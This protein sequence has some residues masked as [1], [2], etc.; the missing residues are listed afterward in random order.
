MDVTG[1]NEVGNAARA[2]GA[3]AATT[4]STTV[5][6]SNPSIYA[7][8]ENGLKVPYRQLA[9]QLHNLQLKGFHSLML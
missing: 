3:N 5:A 1:L 9:Q 2:N 7:Q 6:A 4:T 8:V